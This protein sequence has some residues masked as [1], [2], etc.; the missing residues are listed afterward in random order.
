MSKKQLRYRI[1][2]WISFLFFYSSLYI[3]SEFCLRPLATVLEA[4]I[5]IALAV[6]VAFLTAAFN[7]RNSYM[8]ALRDLWQRLVPAAQTAIQYTHLT[9]PD[10]RD[11]ARTQE[12]LSTAIDMLRGVFSN[13]PTGSPP[14]LYPYENLKDIQRIVS[15]LKYGPN[16]RRAEVDKARLC[17]TRLWQEMHVAML[18]EFDRAVPLEPVS[19]YLGSGQSVADL[20]EDKQLKD[21]HLSRNRSASNPFK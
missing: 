11:F 15:L 1:Y 9:S 19:K 17:I 20:L 16:F 21:E 10:Q 14:G 3:Y 13:V 5:P 7:K 6:P 8:R 4:L 12:S 2:F 18:G